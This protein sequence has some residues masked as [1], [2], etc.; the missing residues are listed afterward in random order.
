MEAK[1]IIYKYIEFFFSKTDLHS[2]MT[3]K[4]LSYE[5]WLQSISDMYSVENKSDKNTFHYNIMH[6]TAYKEII[7]LL[8]EIDQLTNEQSKP[9]ENKTDA[10]KIEETEKKIEKNK[11]IIEEKFKKI[12]EYYTQL[13]YYDEIYVYAHYVFNNIRKIPNLGIQKGGGHKDRQLTLEEF[14]EIIREKIRMLD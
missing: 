4:P 3:I 1:D 9:G 8:R 13:Y 2:M 12:K 5:N 14:K 6:T 10:G 7:K 11:P